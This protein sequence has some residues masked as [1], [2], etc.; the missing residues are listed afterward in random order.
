[1]FGVCVFLLMLFIQQGCIKLI[2]SDSKNIYNVTKDSIS[3]KCSF[4]K[5]SEKQN[6]QNIKQQKTLLITDDQ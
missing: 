6:P 3:K 1:M 2:K 4:S 5:N